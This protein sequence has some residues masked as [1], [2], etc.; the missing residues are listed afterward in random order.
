MSSNPIALLRQRAPSLYS[1]FLPADI[2]FRN[3]LGHSETVAL[4]VATVDELA[5][6][7]QALN[8]EASAITRQR[9]ALEDL[10]NAL[11]LRLARGADRVID[12]NLEG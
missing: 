9:M 5:F 2:R 12:V 6:A 4:E 10:Y 7:I 3:G 8:R 11:R 1:E